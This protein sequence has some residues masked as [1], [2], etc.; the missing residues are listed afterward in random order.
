MQ[1]VSLRRTG[2]ALAA[3]LTLV[4]GAASAAH[5]F[6][7]GPTGPAGKSCKTPEGIVIKSGETG[8]SGG[9]TYKC[10]NGVGCQVENGT[11]TTKCSH[12][13]LTRP[14]RE[15]PGAVN[16]PKPAVLVVP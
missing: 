14:P 11:V 8:T 12:M 3:A 9:R 13:A 2:P 16:A 5:A 7:I 10:T 1:T 15:K 6:P 4:L